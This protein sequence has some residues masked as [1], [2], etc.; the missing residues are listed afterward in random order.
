LASLNHQV[1]D[2]PITLKILTLSNAFSYQVFNL[3]IY[4]KELSLG[5]YSFIRP[6]IIL[7]PMLR[8][9]KLDNGFREIIT[10]LPPKL[11]QIMII[12][13]IKITKIIKLT[14]QA[15]SIVSTINSGFENFLSYIQ[16]NIFE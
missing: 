8:T 9:I 15:K 10:Q 7:P 6:L 4:L 5:D 11:K 1:D 13:V 3:P 2:L 12:K 16:Y 14:E